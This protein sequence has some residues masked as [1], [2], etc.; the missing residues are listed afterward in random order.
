[1]NEIFVVYGALTY[2]QL[3][4]Q[5]KRVFL[6]VL[7]AVSTM[8]YQKNV[9]VGLSLQVRSAAIELWMCKDAKND[10]NVEIVMKKRVCCSMYVDIAPVLYVK[11]VLEADIVLRVGQYA[12]IVTSM[13]GNTEFI[14]I[15]FCC[16]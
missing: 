10:L 14:D 11:I 13:V 9:I 7:N 2:V 12:Q 6:N 15:M 8:R 4:K 1:M 16:E 3:K 5:I